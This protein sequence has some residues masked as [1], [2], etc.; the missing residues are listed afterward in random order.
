MA[1]VL[2]HSKRP[3]PSDAV[4]ALIADADGLPERTADAVEASLAEGPAVGA[5][6]GDE[7]V[8]FARAVTDGQLRGYVEDV[9]VARAS[10][11]AGI[12]AELVQALLAGLDV[13]VVSV[14]CT[15][16]DIELYEG[17]GFKATRQRVLHRRR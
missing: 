2:L 7:L 15:K 16:R 5:W 1:D 8:G 13:E 11:G 3:I 9:V 17:L 4:L 6:D 12:E 14:F 10:R